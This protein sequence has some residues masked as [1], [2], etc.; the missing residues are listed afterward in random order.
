MGVNGI[1]HSKAF[2]SKWTIFKERWGF[3]VIVGRMD[4]STSTHSISKP[5]T[6]IQKIDW[7]IIS[8][9]TSFYQNSLVS[10]SAWVV[11][12]L[13]WVSWRLSSFQGFYSTHSWNFPIFLQKQRFFNFSPTENPPF[14]AVLPIFRASTSPWDNRNRFVSKKITKMQK[15]CL[16]RQFQQLKTWQVGWLLQT[17][18]IVS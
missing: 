11:L 2:R 4:I 17:E 1:N 13:L 16:E 7:F 12:I 18:I 8:F 5:C 15:I 14:R 10:L 3:L 9:R 6:K